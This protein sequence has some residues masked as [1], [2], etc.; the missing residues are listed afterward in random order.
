MQNLLK[1]RVPGKPGG[2][3]FRKKICSGGRDLPTFENCPGVA[4][5][6]GMVMLGFD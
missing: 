4:H 5:G 3:A 2:Q 1:Y 6:R